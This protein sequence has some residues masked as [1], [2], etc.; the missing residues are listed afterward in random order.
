MPRT[1]QKT[2]VPQGCE[3]PLVHHLYLTSQ[4]HEFWLLEISEFLLQYHSGH[5]LG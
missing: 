5:L 2:H 4:G 1:A 3:V